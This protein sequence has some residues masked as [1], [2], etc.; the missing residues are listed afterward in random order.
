MTP[1]ELG[2]YN[3][4]VSMGISKE[5]SAGAAARAASGVGRFAGKAGKL[6][7][8]IMIGSPFK[9]IDQIRAGTALAPGGLIRGGFDPGKGLLGL[10]IGGLMYGY[11]AYE[12]YKIIKSRE[13]NKAEQIGK[14]LGGTLAGLGTWKAFGMLGSTA[15]HTVGRSLGGMLGKG[16]GAVSGEQS[17][18]P[19]QYARPAM[20][21][22]YPSAPYSG[23]GPQQ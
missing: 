4:L 20:P 18:P 15:A 7:K 19:N 9:A 13:P 23:W 22:S 3:T 10:G 17:T 1:Y 12:G 2:H 16:V 21:Q 6:F 14:L 8:D 11:P 5:A